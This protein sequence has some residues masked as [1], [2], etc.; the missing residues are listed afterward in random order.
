M[1]DNIQFWYDVKTVSSRHSAVTVS[2]A[3]L[4]LAMLLILPI[5]STNKINFT[6]TIEILS[7]LLFFFSSLIFGIIASFEYSVLSGD[8]RPEKYR[9]I[10]FI[11][12]S[13][14]FG[15]AIPTLFLGFIFVVIAYF[16]EIP[17]AKYIANIMRAY[18]ILSLWASGILVSRTI[19]EAMTFVHDKENKKKDA[20]YKKKLNLLLINIYILSSIPST[21]R[22]KNENFSSISEHT[23]KLYFT[24]LVFL[25]FISLGY[26]SFFSNEKHSLTTIRYKNLFSKI[27]YFHTPYFLLILFNIFII[28]TLILYI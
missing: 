23:N 28:S 8:S 7:S 20:W 18:V 15:I 2:I 25:A 9:I 11:G 22:I 12:P 5:F 3:G 17:E 26:Y 16:N 1:K 6:S 13:F 4:S 27:V 19:L 10:T 21:L 24:Y 14:S